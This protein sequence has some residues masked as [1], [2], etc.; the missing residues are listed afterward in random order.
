MESLYA[1][2]IQTIDCFMPDVPVKVKINELVRTPRSHVWS[3][4]L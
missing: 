3:P 4:N 2:N 1:D